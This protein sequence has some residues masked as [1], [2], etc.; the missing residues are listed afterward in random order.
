M[1]ISGGKARGI[2]L[3]VSKKG[4][5]RPAIETTRERLFSSIFQSVENATVLDLFAGSGAYGLESLS[6][7]AKQATLVEKN[8]LVFNDLKTNLAAVLKSAS[9]EGEAGRLVNRDVLDFAK[10]PPSQN[11]DIIFIDPPYAEIEKLGPRLFE[12]LLR[13]HC[14]SKDG[15]AVL[16]TPGELKMEFPGW[17]VTRVVGKEKRGSPVHRI[18]SP[19]HPLPGQ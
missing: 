6:R 18:Y 5:V 13:N 9:L 11:Y 4:G 8:R 16:E 17:T 3:K 14:L 7:G 12:L 10:E 2:P 15:F 1:R 19:A